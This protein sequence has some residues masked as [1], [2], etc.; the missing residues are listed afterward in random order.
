MHLSHLLH[1]IFC[2]LLFV[3]MFEN[4]TDQWNLS[5][6]TVFSC[7]TRLCLSGLDAAILFHN[8]Q[9]ISLMMIL[10]RKS[11]KIFSAPVFADLLGEMIHSNYNVL[12]SSVA[13]FQMQ[14]QWC[15]VRLVWSFLFQAANDH[16]IIQIS[17]QMCYWSRWVSVLL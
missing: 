6:L 12:I 8:G 17:L 16:L 4:R 15:S 5:T 10:I 13:N 2:F 7:I 3:K 14:I 1:Q 9:L 11:T